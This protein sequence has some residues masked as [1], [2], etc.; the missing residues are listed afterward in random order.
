MTHAPFRELLATPGVR[1]VCHLRGRL[2]FMA[3]HG[4]ALEEMTDVVAS[5][6]AAR[7]GASYYAVLQP[8]G[9]EHHIPSHRVSPHESAR[10]HRFL[11]HVDTVITIHGFGRHGYW[12]SLLLGG[13]NRAL[14]HHVA[15]HLREHLPDYHV[16]T[17]MERIPSD[18][19]GLHRHN[20]VNLPRRQG[21]QIELPPRVRVSSPHTESLIKALAA[22]AGDWSG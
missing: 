16:E 14:A 2:G 12:T 11:A 6:A 19:R 8:T 1:E 17:D 9:H 4:G 3:Y 22:A 5:A 20:P 7:S 21:L 13:Q 15:G 10:L 18:L